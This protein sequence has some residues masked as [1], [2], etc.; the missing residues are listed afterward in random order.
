M[1]MLTLMLTPLRHGSHP[2]RGQAVDVVDLHHILGCV[3]VLLPLWEASAHVP[4]PIARV[5]LASR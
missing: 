1:L 4:D 5:S 3:D 2:A